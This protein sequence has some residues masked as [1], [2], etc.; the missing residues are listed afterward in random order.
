GIGVDVGGSNVRAALFEGLE[1][2]GEG[3]VRPTPE[4]AG[5]VLDAVCDAVRAVVERHA[6]APAEVRAVGVGFPGVL[7]PVRGV[8][9]HAGNLRGWRGGPVAGPLEA[10]LGWPVAVDND[11]RAGAY[12]ELRAGAAMDVDDVVY[13]SIGTGVGGAGFVGGRPC[14]GSG[15]AAGELGHM[16]LDASAGGAACRCGQTGHVEALL[17]GYAIESA[18]HAATGRRWSASEALLAGREGAPGLDELY[19]SVVRYLALFL[20][21]VVAVLDPQRIVVGGG[22]GTHPAYPVEAACNALQRLAPAWVARDARVV[23]ARLGPWSGLTG[24]AVLALRRAGC[25]QAA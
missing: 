24:A 4:R 7:A 21:T 13:V 19:R 2:R 12:G 3:V 1:R 15:F 6:L 20:A 23:R 16:V 5:A 25:E 18:A 11:V 9:V 8:S 22:L 10:S 14:L 17:S